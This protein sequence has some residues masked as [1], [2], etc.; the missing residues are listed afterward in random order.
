MAGSALAEGSVPFNANS[1]FIEPD[2]DGSGL[3]ALIEQPAEACRSNR[4][5]HDDDDDQGGSAQY[6]EGIPLD[7][8]R[9]ASEKHGTPAFLNN[10]STAWQ[11]Q[12][13]GRREV[14]PVRPES[15]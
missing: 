1:I 6:H 14:Q 13:R 8:A 3:V 12:R 9:P 15:C 2:F 7:R 11:E 10:V 4:G 5:N